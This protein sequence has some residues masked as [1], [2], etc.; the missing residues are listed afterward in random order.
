MIL[1]WWATLM[2]KPMLTDLIYLTLDEL[3]NT[4]TDSVQSDPCHSIRR[5]P[6][7][8]TVWILQCVFPPLWRLYEALSVQRVN[9]GL[10]KLYSPC[11]SPV[12]RTASSL[13]SILTLHEGKK[14]S[15]EET[16]KCVF[17]QRTDKVLILIT[18]RGGDLDVKGDS[19]TE[20]KP[21]GY[22]CAFDF[23][24]RRRIWSH[25]AA[26]WVSSRCAAV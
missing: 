9:P 18:P 11:S 23:I 6:P 3:W 25:W 1:V 26:C 22:E 21:G 16:N 8:M 17:Q 5:T 10:S 4:P 2:I 24:K 7:L 19:G 20:E 12:P 15:P 14:R 13:S